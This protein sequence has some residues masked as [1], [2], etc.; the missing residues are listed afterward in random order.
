[1]LNVKL[2]DTVVRMLAG[3]IPMK[4]V[5]SEVTEDIIT[6]GDYTF[7]RKT[8]AEIDDELGWGPKYGYTGSYVK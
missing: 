7:D 1:M 6:C 2:G 5:V 3:A 4:L 8:G